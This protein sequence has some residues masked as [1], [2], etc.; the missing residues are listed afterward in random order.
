MFTFISVLSIS[1]T[2]VI[3]IDRLTIW[4]VTIVRIC[5]IVF[6]DYL[7]TNRIDLR[8]RLSFDALLSIEHI[9]TYRHCRR[10]ILEL[11]IFN[12]LKYLFFLFRKSNRF[13]VDM[14]KWFTMRSTCLWADNF[15]CQ[16]VDR[17][18]DECHRMG[19]VVLFSSIAHS[20]FRVAIENFMNIS[21]RYRIPLNYISNF[22]LA[23]EC[24]VRRVR[25]RCFVSNGIRQ[26]YIYD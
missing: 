1:S 17:I 11:A 5:V 18:R 6:V 7:L 12:N 10:Q 13:S 22:R 3:D 24:R 14:N 19:N 21:L 2:D 16:H 26:Y 4:L 25:D 8:H 9:D 20:S 23:N 15:W